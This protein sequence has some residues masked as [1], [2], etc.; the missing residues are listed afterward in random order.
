MTDFLPSLPSTILFHTN[1]MSNAL[2]YG[3]PRSA[4]H[5]GISMN[6]VI[7]LYGTGF[8]INPKAISMKLTYFILQF[9]SNVIIN[10]TK[11]LPLRHMW[12]S[13]LSFLVYC[14]QNFKLFGFPIFFWAYLMKVIPEN[15]SCALNLISTFY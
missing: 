5:F 15:A 11:V 14:S 6:R 4:F 9:L 8:P 10:K 3:M 7:A 1:N 13:Y 2:E 12:L